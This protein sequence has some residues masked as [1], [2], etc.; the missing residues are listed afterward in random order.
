MKKD[1]IF[2]LTASVTLNNYSCGCWSMV[3]HNTQLQ[4]ILYKLFCEINVENFEIIIK[5]R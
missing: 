2:C 5:E 3:F 1:D 4:Y